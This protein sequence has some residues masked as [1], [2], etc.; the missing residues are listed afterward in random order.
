MRDLF[1]Y[2][3]EAGNKLLEDADANG[4]KRKFR[5]RGAGSGEEKF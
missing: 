3:G 1:L 2:G 4:K 5:M